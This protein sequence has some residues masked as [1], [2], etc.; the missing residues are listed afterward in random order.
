MEPRISLI[1]LG[2]A[3]LHR[4][5]EFYRDGLGL[6][7]SRKPEEGVVFFRT[8]GV[9]LALYPYS[10]L[11][12]DV[13]PGWE[14]PRSKF[15]GITIAHN[16]RERHQV[17]EVLELAARAGAEIVKPAADTSWGGYGGYFTDPDGYLW[18]IAWGAFPFHEDGSLDVG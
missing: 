4:S 18:E 1:T 6:P 5:Y 15:T 7:T 11:A 17:D 14:V 13:G 12:G 9:V 2:V 3:D 10:D 16:V 8:S